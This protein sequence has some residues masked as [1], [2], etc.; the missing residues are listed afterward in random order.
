MNVLTLGSRVIGPEPAW[1][2]VDCL[3]RR[4]LQ[5][6]GP[7]PA[8]AGQGA[9]DR[10][11]GL[12]AGEL[13]SASASGLAALIR[14]REV[15]SEDVV[16]ACLDRIEAVN[17]KINAVVAFAEDAL[18][19]A[20]ERGC[21][22]GGG[23]RGRAAPWRAVHGE[24]LARHRGARDDGRDRRVAEPRAGP[25]MRRSLPGSATPAR[26]SS[27]RRTRPS[28]PGRTRPTTTSTAGPPTRTTSRRTPGGS[29]GGAAAIVAAGGSP[30]DIG[31][32]TG[33]SIRQPAHVCGIAG[34]KPTSG[35]VP[36]TGHWPGFAG[37]TGPL[38]QLG[39]SPGGS[40]TSRSCCPVIAG[41][42]GEDPYVAAGRRSGDPRRR[43]TWQG[44][45]W[46]LFTDN[47]IRTPTAETIAAV[48][49]AATRAGRR[50]RARSSGRSRRACAEAWDAWDRLDPERRLRLAP[51]ADRRRRHAR[52]RA[53]TTRAAGST[54]SRRSRA[55]SCRCCSSTPIA[56]AARLHHWFQ[57]AD[58]ILCPAMP[59]PADPPRR[60]Q[61]RVV[62]RHVQRRPQP[63]R[64]AGGRRPRRDV[65][66]G[67][68][69]GV[70]LVARAWREDVALAAA[71]VVEA[72]AA[73]GSA[74]RS[75]PSSPGVRAGWPPPRK[76]CSRSRW[77]A[78]SRRPTRCRTVRAATPRSSPLQPTGSRAHRLR[79]QTRGLRLQVPTP[80]RP[81]AAAVW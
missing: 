78:G 57:A 17:P 56:S 74:R 2:C 58:L 71:R 19:R 35:R 81:G 32:D 77:R 67:L 68:P 75:E 54:R 42:D 3:P 63:H 66:E 30:F 29:S 34:I 6:R 41:P 52:P 12:T 15:S 16:A 22:T 1:E 13:W 49:A 36:R 59:Q 23:R 39:R 53:R 28:S 46:S 79:R 80:W 51:A 26:S 25:A 45:A 60:E 10:G 69:I 14:D 72:A 27:A 21:A 31:S 48:E 9:R 20:R 7:P 73:G 5:R 4:L 61:R 44:S 70:Q 33:D 40:T 76:R 55:T 65:A 37:I 50:G 47:G 11:R 43:A 18:E 62:R 38:T 24:G 64:L 8:A